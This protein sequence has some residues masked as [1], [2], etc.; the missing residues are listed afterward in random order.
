MTE[1]PDVLG[2]LAVPRS[3]TGFSEI[4]S[5]IWS[6][7]DFLRG[8]YKRADYGK[9]ILPLTVLRRL[10]CVLRDTKDK[11]LQR[12]ETLKGGKVK[13]LD[14][15]LN[16]ITGVPFH[17]ISRL[18]FV[19]LKGDPN[20]IATNLGAYIRGF[21]ANAREVI[22]RFKFAEQI[23][24][25]DESNLLFQVLTRFAEIDLHPKAVPNHVMGSISEE[26]IRRFSEQ[27]NE[28]AGK[29]FIPR[30][31]ICLIVNLLFIEDAEALTGPGIVKTVY[32]PACGTGGMLSVAEE[33]LVGCSP[34]SQSG[35]GA[36]ET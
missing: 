9:V 20:H 14:P 19:K 12:H 36:V 4:T 17:N 31:V 1:V 16:R 23:A 21:L 24:K 30:E 7:A 33:F 34:R 10:D 35:D 32:D 15:I 8:D 3:F 28:T 29:H 26:L 27:S 11:V 6:V 18:D 13:N 2:P 5:F 22:E 25:L